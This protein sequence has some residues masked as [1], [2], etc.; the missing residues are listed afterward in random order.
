MPPSVTRG[1]S[2]QLQVK[3]VDPS[4]AVTDV[5]GSPKLSID[6]RDERH[7]GNEH[8]LAQDQLRPHGLLDL[9]RYRASSG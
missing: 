6:R 1:S 3:M 7:W 2:F 8:V 4:A 5:T 9:S